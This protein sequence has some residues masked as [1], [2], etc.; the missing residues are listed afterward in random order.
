MTI[1]LR[2]PQAT[3]PSLD[4]VHQ[5]WVATLDAM[6]DAVFVVDYSGRILRANRAF[7]ELA[8]S[9]FE[10]V[11]G[12]EVTKTL[13][14]L[15]DDDGS[16]SP[17]PK[18]SLDG[19]LFRIRGSSTDPRL[20][21]QIYI[22]E[23]VTSE[24]ALAAAEA[25]YK[26]RSTNSLIGTIAT[27]CQALHA[28][29]PYTAEH[30]RGVAELSRS[31]AQKLGYGEVEA[32]GIFYGAQVHDIGKLSVPGSILNRS[33]PLAQAELNLIRM[34]AEI[35]HR[36]IRNLE[37]PWPVHEIVLQHHER[38]DGSGYPNGLS[39]R[40]ISRAARIVAVADVVE[41]MSSHRPYRPGLGL[42]TAIDEIKSGS[43]VLYD[44]EI[45]E[46]CVHV[47]D[48]DPKLLSSRPSNK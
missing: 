14:W 21:G 15:T 17:Q 31:I 8:G 23:D 7:A 13:P 28:I 2:N 36:I 29:D 45:V 35:G 40:H 11:I 44:N 1:E 46:A 12:Q 24:H 39:G 48:E 16:V 41:A 19:R 3:S 4:A 10:G 27:L 33:G 34:H 18:L 42:E 26:K 5:Q 20:D 32:Q 43:G 22:L 30:G 6:R 47:L 37:F 9:T 38:L 25:K